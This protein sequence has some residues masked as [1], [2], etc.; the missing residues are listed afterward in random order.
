MGFSGL[1]GAFNWWRFGGWL[2]GL[3]WLAFGMKVLVDGEIFCFDFVWESGLRRGRFWHVRIE[4][5]IKEIERWRLRKRLRE[6]EGS[7]QFLFLLLFY[8]IE[9]IVTNIK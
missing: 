2:V 4:C 5:W 6:M 1:F 9:E 3:E 8:K 7:L